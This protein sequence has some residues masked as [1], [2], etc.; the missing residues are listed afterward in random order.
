MPLR[1]DK[2]HQ[3]TQIIVNTESGSQ[4]TLNYKIGDKFRFLVSAG[5]TLKNLIIN[6]VDS[7]IHPDFDVSNCLTSL[8]VCCTVSGTT[9]IG[10]E[11]CKQVRIPG[12]ECVTP[13]G[14]PFIEFDIH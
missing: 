11:S 10:A 8:G 9:L 3:T 4:V 13:F 5:L 7:T 14:G 1:S 12:E 2:N 6:A